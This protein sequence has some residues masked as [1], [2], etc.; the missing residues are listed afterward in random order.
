MTHLKDTFN[1]EKDCEDLGVTGKIKRFKLMLK[2]LGF[3]L[4]NLFE[5]YNL[6]F[7]TLLIDGLYYFLARI[8]F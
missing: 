2:I 3:R 7:S 6:E 4:F 8:F 1:S 5:K